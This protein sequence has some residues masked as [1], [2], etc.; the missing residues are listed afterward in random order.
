MS[1]RQVYRSLNRAMLATQVCR[2]V[3]QVNLRE[4]IAPSRDRATCVIVKGP[5]HRV[6]RV[7]T[8]DDGAASGPSPRS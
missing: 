1:V 5:D 8:R 2:G 4:H 6:L 7:T 3:N